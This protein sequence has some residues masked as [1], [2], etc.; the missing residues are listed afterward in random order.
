MVVMAGLLS[1][2]SGLASTFFKSSWPGLTIFLSQKFMRLVMSKIKRAL[3]FAAERA[4][5]LVSNF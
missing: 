4:N 2:L 3:V 5:A 1:R